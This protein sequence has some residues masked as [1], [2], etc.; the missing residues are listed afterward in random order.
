MEEHKKTFRRGIAVGVA[1]T[2]AAAMLLVGGL[3]VYL[4][5]GVGN[6]GVING[7]TKTKLEYL[8]SLVDYYFY[9]DVDR[10]SFKDGLYKGLVESL[11]D[12]Y[13]AYY[14]AEE[15]ESVTI[16]TQ[17]NY[18]GIGAMLTQSTA[19]RQIFVLKVYSGSPAE[20]AGVKEGDEILSADGVEVGD[21]ML[22][23]YV[24]LIRGEVG[25]QVTLQLRRNGEQTLESVITRAQVAVPSVE[26]KMLEG[27]VGYIEISEFL[28]NT[29]EQFDAAVADLQSQGMESVIFD[30]RSNGGGLVDSVTEILDEI[31][32]E[33]T[34]VY[35]EDK[36]GNREDYTSDA[37]HYMSCPIVVLVSQN[38]ASAAEIFAGAIRDYHY[39]T[40]IGTRTFG[41]GI[42]QTTL[43]LSDGS[44]IKLTTARYYTPSGECIHEKG[45]SPDI[46]MEYEFL[47][48]ENEEYT[49]M[50]DNQICRALEVLSGEKK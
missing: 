38:T 21:Y 24:K 44:A 43:P 2:L 4:R 35:M 1:V 12:P 40:L 32:P 50:K 23:E 16:D 8:I 7:I 10:A 45:I 49:E 37:E 42:V 47:G 13:S 30:L 33:G 17:G 41:K 18:A 28:Q 39:G 14:T 11:G 31:L 20:A 9:E 3:A 22:D 26:Y 48:D 34:T 46:E 25:T 27:H 6:S 19:T 36:R 29:R 15:Y 5:V